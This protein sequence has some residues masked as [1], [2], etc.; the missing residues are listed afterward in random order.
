MLQADQALTLNVSLKVGS[1]T[2]VVSVSGDAPQVDTT[3]GI[4]SQVIDES[5]VVTFR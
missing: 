5:R 3:T 1:Q 2:Q 4:L